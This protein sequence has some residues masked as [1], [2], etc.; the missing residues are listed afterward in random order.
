MTMLWKFL[1]L[2]KVLDE[3]FDDGWC[4]LGIP[5]SCSHLDATLFQD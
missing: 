4:M 1:N 5:V 2:G 3:L